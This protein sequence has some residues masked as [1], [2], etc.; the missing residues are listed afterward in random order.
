[1]SRIHTISIQAAKFALLA[2][3]ATFG[4]ATAAHADTYL[5]NF[6]YVG[7]AGD[8]SFDPPVN[9]SFDESSILTSATTIYASSFLPGSTL[10]T[11]DLFLDPIDDDC[12]SAGH[13]TGACAIPTSTSDDEGGQ[14]GIV[15][16]LGEVPATSV[17][18]YTASAAFA[19]LSITNLSSPAPA[20]EPSSLIL[21]GTGLLGI[22]GAARH[23]LKNRSI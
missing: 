2:V 21:L 20:P 3:F 12:V 15:Q 4:A 16:S 22:F 19:H 1:M 17:G 13:P 14:F 5:Y 18:T 6:V 10:T 9:V 23:R 7:D 8:Y 11:I